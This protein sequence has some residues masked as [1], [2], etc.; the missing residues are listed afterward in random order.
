MK[1]I[2]IILA[3]LLVMNLMGCAARPVTTNPSDTT[4]TKTPTETMWYQNAKLNTNTDW[5]TPIVETET[6]FYYIAEDGVYEYAKDVKQISQIIPETVY[7]LYLYEEN[8][9]YNTEHEVKCINLHTESISLIW[10]NTMLG[11]SDKYHYI[12]LNDFA[13]HDGH[14]YIAGTRTSVMRVNL[15]DYTTEQF[16]GDCGKMVLLSN[17]CYYLDHAERTF[18][19]YHMKC[20]S[21]ESTLLRG[22]GLSEPGTNKLRIDGIAGMEDLIVYSVRDT[23]DVYLY[24]PD[25][26]DEKIFDGGGSGQD[27]LFFIERCPANK[28]Y[29]Y[30]TDKSMLK[31]YEYQP[32]T[33]I[34][35]L[36]SFDCSTRICDIVI[37]ETTAFLYSEEESAVKCWHIGN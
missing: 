1:R 12:S 24:H 14:L 5:S 36:T 22:E 9:Y 27:W 26:N 23:S 8:L 2:G 17:E 29:F 35:L 25:G 28:L 30:T 33:G 15:E 31:L 32:E 11:N 37:T 7:G 19:L 4:P 10:D 18:S 16:L 13:L 34:S 21:K 20:D 3:L 6:H